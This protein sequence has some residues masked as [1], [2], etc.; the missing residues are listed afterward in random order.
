[1]LLDPAEGGKARGWHLETIGPT[2]QN[3]SYLVVAHDLNAIVALDVT[4]NARHE[5]GERHGL[6]DRLAVLFGAD[7]L[8][9]DDAAGFL[10]V[11]TAHPGRPGLSGPSGLF[12]IV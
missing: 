2:V 10:G 3:R 4:N 5:V 9:P 11:G 8:V 6:V 12:L 7:L 1:M